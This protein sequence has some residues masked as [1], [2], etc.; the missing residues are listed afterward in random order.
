M[1][2]MTNQVF[3]GGLWGKL[4]NKSVKPKLEISEGKIHKEHLSFDVYRVE[5]ADVYGSWVI[6]IELSDGDNN[7]LMAYA[8]DDLAKLNK[9]H[10]RNYYIAKIK[11]SKHSM[12]VPLGAK[13]KIS[14]PHPQLAKLSKGNY[15]LK[16]TD[17]SGL[18]WTH[19][20]THL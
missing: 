14:L 19:D 5:G 3:H 7:V 2:L 18:Y 12:L 11:A 8:Q 1:T 16:I 4:H 10:I 15:T 9:R 13:A 20:I 17:I 6:G